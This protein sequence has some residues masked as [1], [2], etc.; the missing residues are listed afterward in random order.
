MKVVPLV[1]FWLRRHVQIEAMFNHTNPG[2]VLE[3][4]AAVV[5]VIEKRWPQLNKDGILDDLLNTLVQAA[6]DPNIT[7]AVDHPGGR[8]I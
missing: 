3:V 7:D 5:P 4:L 2:A 1:E 8:T 6:D